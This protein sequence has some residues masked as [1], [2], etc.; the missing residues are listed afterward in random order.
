MTTGKAFIFSAPSGS[1]KTTIVKHLLDTNNN[2]E[3][4]GETN[5]RQR[6]WNILIFNVVT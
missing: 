6:L 4:T 2:L 5:A 3:F 1:G